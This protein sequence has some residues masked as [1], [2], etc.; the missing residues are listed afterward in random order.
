MCSITAQQL[1]GAMCVWKDQG[2]LNG[3]LAGQ[4]PTTTASIFPAPYKCQCIASI[5]A[6]PCEHHCQSRA[7]N[8]QTCFQ[9]VCR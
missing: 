3:T 8:L 6:G 9:G 7:R 5:L 2:I 1:Q 4:C